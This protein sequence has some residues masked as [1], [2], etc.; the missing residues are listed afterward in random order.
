MIFDVQIHRNVQKVIRDLPPS[1]QKQF[2]QLID[3]L[4]EDP[5]PFKKYDLVR[6]KGHKGIFRIRLGDFR[7]TYEVDDDL[8]KVKLLKLG[9]RGKA[10]KEL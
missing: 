10:Y 9:P 2:A 8:F 1:H 6:I 5:V 3:V 4:K 7:L